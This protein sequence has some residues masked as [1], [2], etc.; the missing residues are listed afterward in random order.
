MVAAGRHAGIF[1]PR[2]RHRGPRAPAGLAAA[3]DHANVINVARRPAPAAMKQRTLVTQRLYFGLDPLRLREASGRVLARVVGLPPERANVSAADLR[4]DLGL[5]TEI[6]RAVVDE[7]VAE[8]LLRPREGATGQFRLTE[9]FA[10]LASARV[11][12]P[13][14]RERARVIVGRACDLARTINAEWSRNP[15]VV[16]AIAPHGEYLARAPILESLPLCVVVGLRPASRRAR[17]RMQPKPSGARDIRAAYRELSSF[18]DI[19]LATTTR[20]VPSPHAVVFHAASEP[21]V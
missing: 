8:G 19:G 5:D 2:C 14:T 16:D 3:A 21:P 15:L 10:E 4:R 20:D 11:V 12:E 18:L 13:L 17:F 7:M 6:G 9:R 1:A